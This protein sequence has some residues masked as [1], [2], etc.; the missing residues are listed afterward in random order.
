MAKTSVIDP[1]EAF[2]PTEA[3]LIPIPEI[4][5]AQLGAS[6][7]HPMPNQEEVVVLLLF[8]VRG[9]GFRLAISSV[10]F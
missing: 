7:S 4:L 5:G 3:K 2:P 9:L 1:V 10:N 8:F 6:D